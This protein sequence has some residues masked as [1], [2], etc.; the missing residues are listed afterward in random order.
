MYSSFFKFGFLLFIF[1]QLKVVAQEE[2]DKLELSPVFSDHMVLQQKTKVA[3]W[4]KS[5]PN[6]LITVTGSWRENNSVL[7]DYKGNWELK[8]LTPS[9]GGP[10]EVEIK[11]SQQSIKYRDVLIG[12]VWLASGQSNMGM[13]LNPSGDHIENQENEISKALYNDIRFFSAHK[14][15]YI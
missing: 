2:Q 14:A 4:G 12:E 5:K 11:T 9:A 8:I 13:T 3:F 10:F 15:N 1:F 6:D 7:A